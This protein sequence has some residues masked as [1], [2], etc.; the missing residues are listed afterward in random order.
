VKRDLPEWLQ[1]RIAE[2][3]DCVSVYLTDEAIKHVR[4]TQ[5]FMVESAGSCFDEKDQENL[6]IV[7]RLTVEFYYFV[8][9]NCTHQFCAEYVSESIMCGFE[10]YSGL[11]HTYRILEDTIENT[12]DWSRISIPSLKEDFISM[13]RDFDKEI[14]FERKCRLLL[15]LFKLQMIFAAV[16]YENGRVCTRSNPIPAF[17]ESGKP[18]L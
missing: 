5:A 6:R 15:D 12:I 1:A 9:Q 8:Q 13:F 16:F 18:Q 3:P 4:R 11:A 14:Y 17:G 7:V 10:W 2:Y